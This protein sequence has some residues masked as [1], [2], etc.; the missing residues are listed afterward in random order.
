MEQD[1]RRF[2]QHITPLSFPDHHY[3]TKRDADAI[4]QALLALPKPHII[5][6]T[7]K[8]AARLMHLQGLSQ[9]VKQ[10]T[11]VLPIEISIMR[12]EKD[13]FNKTIVDYVRENKRNSSMAPRKDA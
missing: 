4:H 12:D 5:I 6:T 9:E 1:M 7:E 3:Y 8:D 2:V 11:Y 13:K 10:G